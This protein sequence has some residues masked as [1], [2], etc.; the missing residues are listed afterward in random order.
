MTSTWTG[1]EIVRRP[2]VYKKLIEEQERVLEGGKKPLDYE[3]LKEMTYLDN[4]IHETLRLH[5]P[6]MLLVRKVRKDMMHN[7]YNIPKGS[8][9][10]CSPFIQHYSEWGYDRP[11]E[12]DPSRFEKSDFKPYSYVAFGAGKHACI[13]EKFAFLQIK[14]IWSWL[15]RN[16]KLN[17]LEPELNKPNFTTMI[18]GPKPPVKVGYQRISK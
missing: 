6:L 5:P 4:V 8:L 11:M 1:L 14:T 13:G 7:G 16:Y 9:V 15:L 17:H 10:C 3:R 18:V 12:F 2:E